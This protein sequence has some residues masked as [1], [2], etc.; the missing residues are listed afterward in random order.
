MLGLLYTSLALFYLISTQSTLH[1][2]SSH[3]LSCS[4][5]GFSVFP[6]NTATC[7]KRNHNTAPYKTHVHAIVLLLLTILMKRPKPTIY[8][9]LTVKSV[10]PEP[11][12]PYSSIFLG[13]VAKHLHRLKTI[14]S[15]CTT[16]TLEKWFWERTEHTVWL[17][18]VQ[19]LFW[20]PAWPIHCSI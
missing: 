5:P 4:W 8:C 7:G 1:C 17:Y 2:F 10:N 12:L 9:L 11:D 18:S 14:V 13:T 6:Q 20:A 16:L 19:L 15:T 3:S